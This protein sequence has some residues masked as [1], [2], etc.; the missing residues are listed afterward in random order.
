VELLVGADYNTKCAIYDINS[1]DGEICSFAP[2]V[3]R[4]RETPPRRRRQ[5]P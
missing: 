4:A 3:E 5:A 1:F 2:Q